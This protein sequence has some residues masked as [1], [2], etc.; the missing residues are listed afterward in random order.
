M[1]CW[2]RW[3][4][5]YCLLTTRP[6]HYTSTLN[7]YLYVFSLS[8]KTLLFI[9]CTFLRHY[10]HRR[11]P[12]FHVFH[13]S[14]DPHHHSIPETVISIYFILHNPIPLWLP[15][16]SSLL[17]VYVRVLTVNSYDHFMCTPCVIH[18]T[19]VWYLMWTGDVS[20]SVTVR[21]QNWSD[22]CE[23]CV[24]AVCATGKRGFSVCN[25]FLWLF[26]FGVDQI[27]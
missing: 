17:C 24:R 26:V 21:V 8:C 16:H 25:D 18:W 3:P 19:W 14:L 11:T 23:W 12:I 27:R 7:E 13:T 9:I 6:F 2:D 10:T 15:F 4:P 20:V 5:N 1:D 22:V